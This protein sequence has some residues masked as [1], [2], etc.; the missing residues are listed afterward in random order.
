M[1]PRRPEPPKL[2][3]QVQ[4][5]RC[6]ACETYV[7]IA[8]LNPRTNKLIHAEQ[9]RAVVRLVGILAFPLLGYLT[10]GVIGST[11][12]PDS[13][14]FSCC[15]MLTLLSAIMIAVNIWATQRELRAVRAQRNR[16]SVCAHTWLW[17]EGTPVPEYNPHPYV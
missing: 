17:Q 14:T 11:L 8:L 12:G 3:Q 9:D 16:C 2:T 7:S 6:G 5:P 13:S 4:C 10:F 15:L 1:L